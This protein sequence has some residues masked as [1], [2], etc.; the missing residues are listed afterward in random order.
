MYLSKRINNYSEKKTLLKVKNDNIFHMIDQIT[1]INP[2]E[3]WRDC[4]SGFTF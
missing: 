1:V 3:I 2:I 4:F